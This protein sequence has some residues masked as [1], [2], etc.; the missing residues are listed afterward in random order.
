MRP[1]PRQSKQPPVS[2]FR[3]FP[4]THQTSSFSLAAPGPS[5][6]SS[7]FSLSLKTFVVVVSLV[8]FFRSLVLYKSLC[9]HK[10]LGIFPTGFSKLVTRFV[11]GQ[12]WAGCCSWIH[13]HVSSLWTLDL[14]P[15]WVG[16]LL[17]ATTP[18][19]VQSSISLCL[20]C[21]VVCAQ[22]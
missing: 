5:S 14:G 21:W 3:Q 16:L 7:A 10:F 9:F 20:V 2:T 12:V 4:G 17:R 15:C 22:S 8:I 6:S 11:P 13:A 18:R 19:S 1:G